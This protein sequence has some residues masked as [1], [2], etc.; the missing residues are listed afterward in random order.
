MSTSSE[1][2]IQLA[3]LHEGQRR[4]YRE[5][6]SR[7]VVRC[8]RRFGKS[9]FFETLSEHWAMQGKRVGYFAPDNKRLSESYARVL[10]VLEPAKKSASKNAGEIRLKKGRGNGPKGGGSIDFWTLGD[11]D[12]GRS[13][14]Y[15]EVV[16]DEAGMVKTGLKEIVQQ[17]IMPTLLVTN[18]NILM[19]GTPLG[20][21][22]DSFFY[23]ACMN[24]GTE[25]W[26]E[27]HMPSGSNPLIPQATLDHFKATSEP[28]VWQQEYLAEFVDWRGASFFSIDK[29]T[30]EGRGV[31]IPAHCD[32]VF[33]VVDSAMKDGSGNDGTAVVYC[34]R[35]MY[36]GHPL[37]ILDWDIVQINSDM[38]TQWLP[39]VFQNLQHYS[40]LCRGRYGPRTY[41]E[42][43]ASGITLNQHS[44]RMGWPVEAIGGDI[45]SVG[46][47][48]RALM[49]SSPVYRGDVKLSDYALNKTM[50]FKQQE[51]NHLVTQVTSYIVGDKNAAKR[52]D[53]LYDAFAYSVIV[54]LGGPE[55]F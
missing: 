33:A 40:R 37:V 50:M 28:R 34:A 23:E 16:I 29:L 4:I 31:A 36:T 22:D 49:A 17:S 5:R 7:T 27:F 55:G 47:D 48:G 15:D 6:T 46:K 52:S 3:V 14:E 12:A 20:V 32:Y 1:T 45:T 44:A 39:S 41:I 21:S 30:V 53:D 11:P 2:P 25:K 18:G 38:L 8:G 35:S 10:N 26:K 9:L 42:D 54:A 13:R 24:Q 51:K 43:K 19:G